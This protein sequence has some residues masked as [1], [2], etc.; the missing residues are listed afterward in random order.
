MAAHFYCFYA[1]NHAYIV[2]FATGSIYIEKPSFSYAIVGI[3][4]ARGIASSLLGGEERDQKLAMQALKHEAASIEADGV[5]ISDSR[6]EI[7]SVSKNGTSTARRIKG[8]A[9]RRQ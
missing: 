8:L 2:T 9:I 4:E 5:I 6:Q 3:V 7:A 1:L